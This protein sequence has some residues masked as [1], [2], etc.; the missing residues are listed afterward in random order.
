MRITKVLVLALLSLFMAFVCPP[1][2]GAAYDSM[3]GLSLHQ[4]A[5]IIFTQAQTLPI[6]ARE[7]FEAKRA[8][9]R[10]K[11]A[12]EATSTAAGPSISVGESSATANDSD[13]PVC[14]NFM[15][16]M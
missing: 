4:N 3:Q 8:R 13:T 12:E 1:P 6:N 9:K 10:Q 5:C 15:E 2:C 14:L 11:L 16:G 7:R